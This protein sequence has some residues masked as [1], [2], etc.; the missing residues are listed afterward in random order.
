[1]SDKPAVSVVIATFNRAAYLPATIDSVLNQSFQDFEVIVVDDGSTD[2]TQAV[3]A[4]YGSRLRCFHQANAGASAARNFG[5]SQARAPWI[6]FQDSDDLSMPTHLETLIDFVRKHHDRG[7][8]F[9]NGGYLE[10]RRHDTIIP[11][12]Q[13]RRL[14]SAGVSLLDLFEK[15]IVRLQASILSKAAYESLG[16][17]DE[18]LQICHDLDLAFRVFMRYPVKYCNQ[19][20]FLYRTHHGSI[21]RNE[22]IRL[23]ENIRV[24]GKLL[25]EHPEA[26]DLIGTHVVDNRL[27]YRYYR[28]A[29]ARW[30]HNQRAGARLAIQQAVRLR[31]AHLKYRLYQLAMAAYDSKN[32]VQGAK[33]A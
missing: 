14:E 17:M 11:A 32:R 20:V 10:N 24:I 2:D 30:R 29:K 28:L 13:S 12:H 23:T 16:G 3:L 1:M 26:R 33:S 21:T 22:E 31:P 7:M 9:A 27:A 5:V 18:S 19:V 6:A 25:Q 8:V 4:G 15:S